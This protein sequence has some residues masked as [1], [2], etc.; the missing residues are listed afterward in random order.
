MKELDELKKRILDYEMRME[1]LIVD[2]SKETTSEGI[3]AIYNFD[4]LIES[5]TELM[6]SV[7][8]VS[9]MKNGKIMLEHRDHG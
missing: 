4:K 3:P 5:F 2:I 8:E 7:R 9:S 1:A 6:N